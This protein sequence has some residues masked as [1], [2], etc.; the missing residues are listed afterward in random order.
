MNKK[1]KHITS[2]E[3]EKAFEDFLKLRG[4]LKEVDDG[5]SYK[6]IIGDAIL[7]KNGI[8]ISDDW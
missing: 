2:V 8:N 5:R 4:F 3:R 1:R 6:D 7:E